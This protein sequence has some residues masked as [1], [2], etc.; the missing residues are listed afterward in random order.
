MDARG[1]QTRDREE[2]MDERRTSRMDRALAAVCA[3][4]P[5]CRRARKKQDGMANRFVRKV[6]RGACPFCR[7]YERV[8]GRKSFEP[9]P[10]GE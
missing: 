3:S 9:V 7:A 8:N 2:G 10:E 6:E 1:G 4:C 5:V